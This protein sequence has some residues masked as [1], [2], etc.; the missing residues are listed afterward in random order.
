LQPLIITAAVTGGG[1]ARANTPHRPVTPQTV[2]DAAV[3]CWR[4][5]AAIVHIHARHDDE[6][7][8]SDVGAYRNIVDRIRAAGCDA[9]LSLSAGDD[10]GKS[11]HE[12]RWAVLEAGEELAS[13]DLGPINLGQ[14]LYD[15]R[16]SYLREMAKRMLERG[17]K[18]EIDIFDS[19]HMNGL[20]GLIKDGLVKP[21]YFVQFV[22]GVPGGMPVDL[23]MLPILRSL[24]PAEAQWSM[25]CAGVDNE[26]FQ[27]FQMN[28]FVDG[29]H[30]RTGMEDHVYVRPGELAKDNAEMVAQW[31]DTARIWGR[32]V[33]STT[34]ARRILGLPT[35]KAA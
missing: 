20:A 35:R 26:T 21:P 25:D 16:P 27:R 2:A 24:L 11:D 3:A 5:G 12:Q 32:P 34:E 19:G 29:G 8:S 7:T 14:R 22:F 17:V 23:R 30:I 18:P 31:V 1:P 6:S 9:V 13:L 10:G 4:A 28:A 15:N 33:A